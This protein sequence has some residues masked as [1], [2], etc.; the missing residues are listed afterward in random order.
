MRTKLG[1]SVGMLGAAAY[2]MVFFGGYVPAL[3][4]AGY[5]LLFEPNEWLRRTVVKALAVAIVFEFVLGI[6]GLVP[7]SLSWI[8]SVVSLF[9]GSFNYS[10]IT[11]IV[12]ICTQAIYIIKTIMFLVLG[13]KALTMR[14][15]IVPIADSVINKYI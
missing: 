11:N 8:S 5:V 2:F 4:I 15:T 14:T 12:N 7:S 3:I 13:V 10:I 9:K 1:V 6:I